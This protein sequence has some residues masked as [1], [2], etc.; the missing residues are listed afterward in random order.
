V[1]EVVRN[2]L[3]VEPENPEALA[4]GILRLYRDPDLRVSLG[5][6]GCQDVQGFAMLRVAKRFLG[7]LA[8]IAPGVKVTEGHEVEHAI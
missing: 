7:E 4:E 2:G 1:P 6:A 3:L 5:E 8:K